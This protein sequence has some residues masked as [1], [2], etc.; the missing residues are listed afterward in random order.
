[1]LITQLKDLHENFAINLK[2][3]TQRVKIYHDKKRFDEIDLKMK[4]KYFY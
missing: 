2:F 3:I 1:M 4:K